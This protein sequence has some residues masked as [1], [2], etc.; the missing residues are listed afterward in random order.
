[1]FVGYVLVVVAATKH[2]I[3]IK[4]LRTAMNTST[5]QHEEH[6]E[7]ETYLWLWSDREG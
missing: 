7:L 4:E 2:T 1:M 5:R 6:N 3:S